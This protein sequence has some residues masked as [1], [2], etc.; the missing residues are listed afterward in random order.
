MYIIGLIKNICKIMITNIF[1]N[2][3]CLMLSRNI[4]LDAKVEV[5]KI[6][7]KVKLLANIYTTMKFVYIIGFYIFR[8]NTRECL[9]LQV[10][11]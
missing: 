10:E 1:R 4:L 8:E 11:W 3:I 9:Y 2:K 5:A 6:P 7:I